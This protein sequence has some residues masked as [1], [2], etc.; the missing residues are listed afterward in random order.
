MYITYHTLVLTRDDLLRKVCELKENKPPL[1]SEEHAAFKHF[2]DHHN[3][4][5]FVVPLP[6][7]PYAKRLREWKYQGYS[8]TLSVPFIPR[9]SL[10]N[11]RICHR[12]VSQ[13]GMCK[14]SSRNWCREN[15]I[16][17][18]VYLR[19]SSRTTA[20]FMWLLVS[21]SSFI[22]KTCIQQNTSDFA[23][24]YPFATNYSCGGLKGRFLLRKWNSSEDSL[25][26]HR[27]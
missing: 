7:R 11:S 24:E 1:S 19:A 26:A 6:K 25:W 23:L 10:Q 8:P 2:K 12:W 18:G 13:Y 3:C 15:T 22:A 16:C 17:G 21:A 4:V 20:Q 5:R 9:G 27:P 14:T